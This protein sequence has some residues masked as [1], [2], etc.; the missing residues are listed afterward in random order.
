MFIS[1]GCWNNRRIIMKD[2]SHP[3]LMSNNPEKVWCLLG[4]L[5]IET[6]GVFNISGMD[7]VRTCR[8]YADTM[9][10][11][12]G[13]S[14][15][16][17][18]VFHCSCMRRLLKLLP[19]VGSYMCDKGVCFLACG[20]WCN[21]LLVSFGKSSC[22]LYPERLSFSTLELWWDMMG[23]HCISPNLNYSGPNMATLVILV[24]PL[25]CK[26]M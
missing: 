1:P 4:D 8:G 24:N 25:G 3:P 12:P 7:Y 26:I 17:S 13:I 20:L 18:C 2:R 15:P 16:N 22:F 6:I 9:L 5:H 10:Y 14:T 21:C 23:Q 11:A 19:I